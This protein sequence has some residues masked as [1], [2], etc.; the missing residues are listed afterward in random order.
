[1][2]NEYICSYW[3]KTKGG[4]RERGGAKSMLN[5]GK[6]GKDH[7]PIEGLLV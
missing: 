2:V 1:M 3:S 5:R 6:D 4:K 7:R